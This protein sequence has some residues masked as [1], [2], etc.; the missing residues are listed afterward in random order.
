MHLR[1]WLFTVWVRL[2]QFGCRLQRAAAS[3]GACVA[4]CSLEPPSLLMVFIVCVVCFGVLF[5]ERARAGW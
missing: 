1:D 2:P 3:G 5:N 4:A